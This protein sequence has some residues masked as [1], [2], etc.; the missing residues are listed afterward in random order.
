[1]RSSGVF[2]LLVVALSAVACLPKGFYGYWQGIPNYS[3]L[4]PFDQYL[5]FTIE[6]TARGWLMKDFFGVDSDMIPGSYQTWRVVAGQDNGV[7]GGYLTYDGYIENFFSYPGPVQVV[8]NETAETDDQVEW[9]WFVPQYSIVGDRM[10]WTLTLT[11]NGNGLTSHLYL[12]SPVTHLHVD[13]KRL[14]SLHDLTP[15]EEPPML[16]EEVPAADPPADTPAACPYK[17][18]VLPSSPSG[19]PPTT[20]SGPRS[21]ATPHTR[22]LAENYD[23]CYVLNPSVQYS[24]AWTL[25]DTSLAVSISVRQTQTNQWVGLGIGNIFPGMIDGDVVLGYP[26]DQSGCVRSMFVNVYVGTPVDQTEQVITDTSVVQEDGYITVSWVRALDTGHHNITTDD[27]NTQIMWATGQSP[28]NSCT[29][30]PFYH[31]NTRGNRMVIWRDPT[32]MFLDF[33]KCT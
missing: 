8:F 27:T 17:K 2:V 18:N 3:P 14:G 33:M 26:T 11:N 6:P 31:L 9:C 13:Y 32:P 23:W 25:S 5:N 29:S 20:V 22:R 30:D 21:L 10:C 24:L 12:A 19:V 15:V 28:G 1:M 16:S 7:T 4:G